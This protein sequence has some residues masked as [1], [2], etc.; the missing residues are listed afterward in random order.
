MN[1][2]R[3][4][5]ATIPEQLK[6]IIDEDLFNY[7]KNYHI[8]RDDIEKKIDQLILRNNHVMQEL[9]DAV[10]EID[11]GISEQTY[12]TEYIRITIDML[13]AKLEHITI[14][15]SNWQDVLDS[16]DTD[17]AIMLEHYGFKLTDRTQDE[18]LYAFIND[19]NILD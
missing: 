3:Y 14:E 6:A 11:S 13:E 19:A 18:Y 4:T 10:H 7:I 9:S 1:C 5:Y 16:I 2:D 15:N 12:T 8:R 17:Y